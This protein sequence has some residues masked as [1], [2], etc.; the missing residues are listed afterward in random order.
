M[1]D[2][3]ANARKQGYRQKRVGFWAIFPRYRR[4]T[5]VHGI[6]CHFRARLSP[7][8]AYLSP[9]RPPLLHVTRLFAAVIPAPAICHSGLDPES[10][11]PS[12]RPY[13]VALAVQLRVG[14]N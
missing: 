10:S 7:F 4:R 5:N 12:H 1:A 14:A 8:R 3:K 13:N 6:V 2:A 9:F 11:K